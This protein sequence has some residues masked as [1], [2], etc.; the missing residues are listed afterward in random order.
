MTRALQQIGLI[1]N[2][3][4]QRNRGRLLGVGSP[5]L[6]RAE[7]ST[8]EELAATLAEFA[9][10]EV[11]LLL[12]SGGDGT[13][14]DV[15]TALPAAYGERLPQLSLLS[16]G[17]ANLIASDVG[18]A[19]HSAA[20]LRRVL[21]AAQNANFKHRISRPALTL[22]WPDQAHTPVRGFFMGAAALSRATR[23]AHEQVLNGGVKYG[24]SV[25]VTVFAA[26]KQTLRGEGDWRDGE[27]MTVTLDE[28]T[29]RAGA[30][31]IFLAT[32]LHKLMLGLWPF[33]GEGGP[34]RY[35]D[36]DAPPPQLGRSLLPLLSGHPTRR[37]RADGYRSGGATRIRL[38]LR[39]PVLVDGETF[40]PGRD[41]IID[42]SVGP[43]FEF[44][45]P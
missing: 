35:V 12:I 37:M 43:E 9:R 15:L 17:N 10:R 34:L 36:I 41:G 38:Q 21:A 32:T 27:P 24:A 11:G 26:F 19:G 31:F 4:S 33:W 18:S 25:A 8:L 13:V 28:G 29:A 40:A 22:S 2:P 7:P 45:T 16:S 6:L 44:L 30:R 5:Q 23:Y 3:R 39:E 20:A 42:L 14:R 1:H